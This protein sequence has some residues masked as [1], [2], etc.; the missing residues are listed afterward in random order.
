MSL[1][2]LAYIDPTPG[3]LPPSMWWPMIASAIAA[4]SGWLGLFAVRRRVRA[5]AA[6]HKFISGLMAAVLAGLTGT[7]V[8]WWLRS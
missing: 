6:A 1:A 7:A 3:G 2:L 8:W 5:F 4:V